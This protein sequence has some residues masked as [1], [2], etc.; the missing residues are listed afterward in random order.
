[1]YSLKVEEGDRSP[2]SGTESCD[3]GRKT[4]KDVLLIAL[5]MEGHTMRQE[6]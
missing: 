1:M 4:Q 6:M 3:Y 5:R 2:E